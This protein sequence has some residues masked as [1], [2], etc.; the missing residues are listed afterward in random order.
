M[1]RR[2]RHYR[3]CDDGQWGLGTLFEHA[4]IP[5]LR[6]KFFKSQ[7]LAVPRE[8]I[9]AEGH[10]VAGVGHG[11]PRGYVIDGEGVQHLIQ[12]SCLVV[13]GVEQN[14]LYGSKWRE[15]K[16]YQSSTWIVRGWKQHFATPLQ[17]PE[18]DLS[19]SLGLISGSGA[20]G[21]VSCSYR[22]T[23]VSANGTSPPQQFEAPTVGR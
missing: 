19:F 7:V 1:G 23:A 3:W 15:M 8:I 17:E 9:P 10:Q 18:S 20:T 21:L 2:Q 22:H 11:L 6:C 16:S 4:I 5:G 13:P 12:I 14:L